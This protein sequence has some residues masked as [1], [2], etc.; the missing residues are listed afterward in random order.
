MRLK[1][2]L[3]NLKLRKGIPFHYKF[4]LFFALTKKPIKIYDNKFILLVRDVYFLIL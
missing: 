1:P 3:Q 4:S 2:G